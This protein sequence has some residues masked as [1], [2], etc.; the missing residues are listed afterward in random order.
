M[1]YNQVSSAGH[2]TPNALKHIHN[3]INPHV[4]GGMFHRPHQ[5]IFYRSMVDTAYTPIEE[6]FDVGTKV[7]FLTFGET[8]PVRPYE[9]NQLMIAD[10]FDMGVQSFE[11]C[12]GAYKNIKLDQDTLRM[13][14]NLE[15]NWPIKVLSQLKEAMAREYHKWFQHRVIADLIGGISTL[16]KGAAYSLG[17]PDAPVV[18]DAVNTEQFLRYMVTHL[19]NRGTYGVT[20][21]AEEDADPVTGNMYF[22]VPA[23]LKPLITSVV[24]ARVDINNIQDHPM[25]K[26]IGY[27]EL[28]GIRQITYARDDFPPIKNADGTFTYP[29]MLGNKDAYKHASRVVTA[30]FHTPNHNDEMNTIKTRVAGGGFLLSPDSCV[31]AYV[32][33]D[34]T[35]YNFNP[36]RPILVP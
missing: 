18:L 21:T 26:Y 36:N 12:G 1:F 17:T 8:T 10:E 22:W 20:S 9:S 3:V 19:E 25:F 6:A 14:N 15:K 30:E 35:N 32:K 16:N 27:N 11:I 28:I 5:N 2:S 7:S 24:S 13:I 23:D 33:L 4:V 31:L 29:I 34:P